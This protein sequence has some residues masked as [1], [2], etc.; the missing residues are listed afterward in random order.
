[1]PFRM[2]PGRLVAV[3]RRLRGMA[4]SGMGVMARF[5]VAAALVMLRRFAMVLGR[6]FV[7][8]GCLQVILSALLRG[9][10]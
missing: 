1:M 4:A 5:F 3:V 10:R 2:L 6:A 9:V 7:V 8:L